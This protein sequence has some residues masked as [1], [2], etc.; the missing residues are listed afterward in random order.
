MSYLQNFV[1]L[2]RYRSPTLTVIMFT[3][4]NLPQELIMAIVD[5]IQDDKKSLR[6]FSLVCKA[7]TN[8]ARDHLFA[9]L[10]ISHVRFEEIKAANIASTY[11]PY[12]RHLYLSS[13]GYCHKF[14]H[15]VIPFL[16]DFSTPRLQTLTLSDFPWHSLSPD[17]RSAFLRQFQSIVSLRLSL[18]EQDTSNDIATIICSFPQLRKLLLLPS[19][20]TCALSGPSPL[21]PELRFPERLLT[22]RVLY[23]HQDYRLFLEWL[24]SIPEQLSIHTLHLY[25]R[26]LSPQDFDTINLFL[27]ALGPSLQVFLWDSDGMFMPSAPTVELF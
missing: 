19:F 14:W 23:F 4:E 13:R 3:C 7:W 8:P 1:V 27:K 11:A 12:L 17:E 2:H 16:A 15:E 24:R 10:N 26:H 18:Y 25:L 22:L 20:H 5:N 9:S 21:S 6:A